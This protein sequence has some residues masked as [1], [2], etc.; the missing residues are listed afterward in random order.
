MAPTLD[1]LITRRFQDVT[2]TADGIDT[3][4]FLEA[5]EGVVKLFDLL[6][7]AAF[8]PVKSDITTNIGVCKVR[9][10]YESDPKAFDTLEKI[11]LAETKTGD[12]KATQGLLWLKR[13]LELTAMGLRRNLDN[14]E[15]ELS[16]SFTEAY[17]NTLKQ[18]HG[19]IV[20]KMFSVAML[21]CPDRKTFYM[22]IGGGKEG[23]K[24][25]L[26]EWVQALQTHLNQL[27]VFYA[28]GGY[29]KGL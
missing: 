26:L 13:G 28:S 16:V 14:N 19:F 6:E 25:Q 3:A 27:N 12:R 29:D 11:V 4:E 10:K 20:K 2:V 23:E 17:N 5:A 24:E 18:F 8:F 21:A 7:S 9:A 1:E 22:K 15:E